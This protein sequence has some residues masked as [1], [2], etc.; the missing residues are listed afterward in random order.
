[1]PSPSAPSFSDQEEW[2]DAPQ[3][4]RYRH[5]G[6]TLSFWSTQ[7]INRHHLLAQL[8]DQLPPEGLKAEVNQ[9]SLE[10]FSI[11]L[12]GGAVGWLSLTEYHKEGATLVKVKLSTPFDRWRFLRWLGWVPGPWW[13]FTFLWWWQA[14]KLARVT[15][16]SARVIGLQE[17]R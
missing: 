10:D 6:T 3:P 12:P 11:A 14:R 4:L 17:I 7:G 8:L 2:D 9:W 15:R 16:E 13:P 5:T 1:V